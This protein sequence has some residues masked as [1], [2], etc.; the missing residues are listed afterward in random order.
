MSF[1]VSLNERLESFSKDDSEDSEHIFFWKKK[2]FF[3]LVVFDLGEF[4]WS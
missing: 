2:A 4:P 1:T 3:N